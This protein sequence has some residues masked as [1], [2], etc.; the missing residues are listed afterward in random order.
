MHRILLPFR[1]LAALMC[2]LF[3][4]IACG[5]SAEEG[6]WLE[7]AYSSSHNGESTDHK[8]AVKVVSSTLRRG[9]LTVKW[10][11]KN[12]ARMAT[13]YDWRN[14][15]VMDRNGNLFSPKKGERSRELQPTETSRMLTVHYTLP[16]GADTSR[17]DW[18]WLDKEKEDL[19]YKIRLHPTGP[20]VSIS[21]PATAGS[22]SKRAPTQDSRENTVVMLLDTF[23]VR[24]KDPTHMLHL[25][26]QVEIGQAYQPEAERLKTQWKDLIIRT[27]SELSYADLEGMD[28][29]RAFHDQILISMNEL[30]KYPMVKRVYFTEFM[31]Q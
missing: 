15:A 13:V 27:I 2:T 1:R 11:A 9:H 19:A 10:M 16:D 26:V 29:K 25:E 23:R 20:G 4:V 30:A 18:G 21:N 28:G 3:L 8:V 14:K 17:L 31:I 12:N 6:E 24:L 5:P 22:N 7:A